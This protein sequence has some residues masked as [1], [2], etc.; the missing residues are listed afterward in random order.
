MKINCLK[1]DLVQALHVVSRAVASK[2]QTPILSGIY[3]KAEKD[4]VEL[5]ATDYAIS[6]L[7]RV[8]AEVEEPGTVI[9]SGRYLQEVTRNLP[10]DEVIIET[11]AEETQVF[12]RSGT[13]H[14]QLLVMNRQKGEEFPTLRHL[15]GKVTFTISDVLLK[16]L[17]RKTAF[18]CAGEDGRPVFTGCMLEL[19]EDEVKMVA[20]NTHRLSFMET[21]L[22]GIHGEGRQFIIPA[23]VLEELRQMMTSEI[24]TEVTVACTYSEISF[25]FDHIYLKA[26]LIEGQ[27]PDYRRV[28]PTDFSTRVT[29][30]TA[31]FLAAISRVSLIAR[32]SDYKVIK[33]HFSG[34]QVHMTSNNPE[35]GQAEERVA[36]TID[37][38]DVSI[39]FNAAYVTDVLKNIETKNFYFSL[40]EPLKPAAIRETDNEA[41]IYIITPVRTQPS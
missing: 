24:P 4:E 18:S 39:A 5:Q 9:L 41:F 40:T 3:L 31:D 21:P 11:D 10:A 13:A 36:A 15:E 1:S 38:P 26:R 20:T 7:C 37:G 2:P 12:I 14:F 25:A 29:L 28:I 22:A 32:A 33:L 34:G 16:T 27:F 17:I 35:I 8:K 30:S 23:K 6:V 19:G